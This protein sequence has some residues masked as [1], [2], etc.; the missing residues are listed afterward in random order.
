MSGDI[1]IILVSYMLDDEITFNFKGSIIYC[2]PSKLKHSPNVY[3]KVKG[4]CYNMTPFFYAISAKLFYKFINLLQS[5]SAM[6][7]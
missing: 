7:H 4:N 6:F 2:Y 3:F 1:S 5:L